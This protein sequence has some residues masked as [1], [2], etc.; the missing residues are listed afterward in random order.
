[1]IRFLIIVSYLFLFSEVAYAKDSE[2]LMKQLVILA[3]R[4]HEINFDDEAKD[5]GFKNFS[6]AVKDYKK[7]FDVR[8]STEQAKSLF[9]DILPEGEIEY[10][11]ENADKL[12]EIIINFR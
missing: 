3:E 8:I 7:E 9:N 4:G 11:K 2:G 1:M 6:D 5:F 10:T 12:F